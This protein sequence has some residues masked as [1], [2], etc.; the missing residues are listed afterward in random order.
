MEQRR[1]LFSNLSKLTNIEKEA[2]KKIWEEVKANHKLLSEC[3]R[4]HDFEPFGDG[5][6]KKERCKKCGG[7][8]DKIHAYYYKQGLK[9]SN[10]KR[11]EKC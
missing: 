1:D 7:T 9:D 6:M 3:S 10:K 11:G 8:V 5:P 2:V 4:P